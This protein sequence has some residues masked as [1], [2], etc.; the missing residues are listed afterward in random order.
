MP[1][2][3][4]PEG[5]KRTRRTGI[6][7]DE[8]GDVIRTE[9]WDVLLKAGGKWVTIGRTERCKNTEKAGYHGWRGYPSDMTFPQERGTHNAVMEWLRE[10][11][12]GDR[13][14][15]AVLGTSNKAA[16]AKKKAKKKAK[17]SDADDTTVK[18]GG[19]EVAVGSPSSAAS[20]ENSAGSQDTDDSHMA[21][22][23]SQDNDDSHDTAAAWEYPFAEGSQAKTASQDD[24]APDL[25]KTD[26]PFADDPFADPF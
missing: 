11:Y 12:L 19:E 1:M 26:D 25:P 17:P 22:A 5:M 24:S 8:K 20:Q 2:S 9:E 6:K 23:D 3:P 16:P 15:E 21:V 7:R 4:Q 18:D 10:V 13:D 14:I